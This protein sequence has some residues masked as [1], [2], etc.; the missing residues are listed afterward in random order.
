MDLAEAFGGIITHIEE[1][2]EPKRSVADISKI[3]ETLNWKP[4]TNLLSWVK[5]IK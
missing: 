5:Q 1:R 3:K 2:L 4:E